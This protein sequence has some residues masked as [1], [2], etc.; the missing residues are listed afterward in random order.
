MPSWAM[1]LGDAWGLG[2]ALSGLF[3]LAGFTIRLFPPVAAD[4][5]IVLVPP[6]AKPLFS[7]LDNQRGLGN[8]SYSRVLIPVAPV[9]FVAIPGLLRQNAQVAVVFKPVSADVLGTDTDD[10][11]WRQRESA[12]GE[13]SLRREAGVHFLG[14]LYISF[15]VNPPLNNERIGGN[16]FG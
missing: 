9:G 10:P 4:E 2:S 13:A 16:R 7:M 5:V 1:R 3:T 6:W 12:G 11:L 14:M 15:A 8:L